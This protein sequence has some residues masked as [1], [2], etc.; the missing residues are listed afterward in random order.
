MT[1]KQLEAI[2]AMLRRYEWVCDIYCMKP[3][4][5]QEYLDLL[6]IYWQD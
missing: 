1:P 5:R 2:A 3:W 6:E 4:H